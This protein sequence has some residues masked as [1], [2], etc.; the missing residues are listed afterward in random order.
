MALHP[1]PARLSLACTLVNCI[2]QIIFC[3]TLFESSSF[4]PKGGYVIITKGNL[5]LNF[6]MVESYLLGILR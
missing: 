1:P 2:G 6:R 3:G 4:L 5:F